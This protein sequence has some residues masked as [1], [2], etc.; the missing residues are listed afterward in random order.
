[1]AAAAAEA[2]PEPFAA[3]PAWFLGIECDRCGKVVMRAR[4]L[5]DIL[6]RIRHDGCSGLAGRTE[7]LPASRARRARCGGSC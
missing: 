1:V 6:H 7:L 4:I 3:F 5:A 2:L